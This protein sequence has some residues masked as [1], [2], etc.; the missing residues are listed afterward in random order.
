[1]TARCHG[2]GDLAEEPALLVA[3]RKVSQ[4]CGEA[5]EVHLPRIE[6][7]RLPRSP[8]VG[9]GHDPHEEAAGGRQG[10]HLPLADGRVDHV[11]GGERVGGLG[12]GFEPHGFIRG[13]EGAVVEVVLLKQQRNKICKVGEKRKYEY[14]ESMNEETR[15]W[16]R[17]KQTFFC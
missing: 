5:R 10:P 11:A 8:H 7:E 17:D 14:D 1:M 3:S 6:P 13:N 9:T 4:P 15:K 16:G 2:R 12:N